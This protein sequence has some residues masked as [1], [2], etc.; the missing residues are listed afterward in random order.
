MPWFLG[1]GL[2]GPGYGVNVLEKLVPSIC[3]RIPL[4]TSSAQRTLERSTASRGEDAPPVISPERPE[5][6][7]VMVECDW[8]NVLFFRRQS[9]DAFFEHQESVYS[10]GMAVGFF[11]PAA[12]S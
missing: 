10:F 3:G 11:E 5:T 9:D 12:C 8:E 4:P 2:V 7:K 1:I 6:V